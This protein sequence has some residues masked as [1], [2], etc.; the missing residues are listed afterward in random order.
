MVKLLATIPLLSSPLT[1][2]K[3]EDRFFKEEAFVGGKQFLY[4]NNADDILLR[5]RLA[6]A[7]LRFFSPDRFLRH[8]GNVWNRRCFY[9][10][11]VTGI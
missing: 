10:S 4:Q 11:D 2:P 1:M 8:E 3:L 7:T 5:T 6:A 9:C